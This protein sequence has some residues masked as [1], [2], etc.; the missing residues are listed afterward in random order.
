MALENFPEWFKL[1]WTTTV[2][3]RNYFAIFC[4]KRLRKTGGGC[5]KVVEPRTLTVRRSYPIQWKRERVDLAELA[6]LRWIKKWRIERIAAHLD[7]GTTT[8]KRH[9]A[10]VRG[11]KTELKLDSRVKKAIMKETSRSFRGR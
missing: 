2:S 9:L 3:E 5:A 4:F 10:E 1:R 6:N 7:L 11:H 8:V